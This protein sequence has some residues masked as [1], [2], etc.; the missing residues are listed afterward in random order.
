M[1]S[2]FQGYK[3]IENIPPTK[4][5]LRQHVLR[6]VLQSSKW[7]ESLCKGFHGRDACQW[8]W[9]NVAKEMIP[10]WN[11]LPQASNVYRELIKSGRKKKM[12]KAI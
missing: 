2:V 9:K 1:D 3:V 11:D 6:S 10:L 8:S 5:A 7:R 4:G 12:H